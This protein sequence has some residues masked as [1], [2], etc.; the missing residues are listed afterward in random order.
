MLPAS[1]VESQHTVGKRNQIHSAAMYLVKEAAI[2][3]G[4]YVTS[5][6]VLRVETAEM[7]ERVRQAV[8]LPAAGGPL[9][10]ARLTEQNVLRCRRWHAN[11]VEDWTAERWL[12]AAAGEL[13]EAAN[14]M[15]KMWRLQEGISN[16]NNVTSEQITSVKKAVDYIGKELADTLLY[17]NLTAVRLGINLEDKVVQVFNAKSEELGFPERL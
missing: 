6:N 7:L 1:L 15:K 9:T 4:S 14:A 17:L 12:L 11:G 2:P 5:Q 16:P 10:F 3:Y 13:G 8:G